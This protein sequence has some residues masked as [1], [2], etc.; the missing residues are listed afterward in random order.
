[1]EYWDD[2]AQKSMVVE[3]RYAQLPDLYRGA[4]P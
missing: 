3:Y 2:D 4:D 1:M